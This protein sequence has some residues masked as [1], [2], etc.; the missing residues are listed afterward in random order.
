MFVQKTVCMSHQIMSFGAEIQF[1]PDSS[2]KIW[3]KKEH[4]EF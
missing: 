4:K 3:I 1:L 2:E